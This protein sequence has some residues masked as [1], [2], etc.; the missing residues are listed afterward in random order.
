[1]GGIQLTYDRELRSPINVKLP[2]SKSM[3]ARALIMAAFAKV[4]PQAFS[5]LPDCNDTRELSAAIDWFFAGS[6][7]KYD[8]GTGGTSLR[9][10]TGFIA[11]IPDITAV[12]TCSEALGKRPLAPL[13]HALTDAG[14]DI[15]FIDREGY[16]PLL[17]S[18]KKIQGG[19]LEMSGNISSQFASSVMLAAP[20][21]TKGLHLK[22][23]GDSP[24]SMPYIHLTA[25]M[26]LNAGA[27][28]TVE[29][30][31]IT[32]A[33]GPYN[34]E[35]CVS[36]I[37]PDWSAASYFY[38]LALLCPEREIHFYR[39]TPP[40]TSLQGD[41]RC[42]DLFNLLGVENRYTEDGG[43]IVRC[44]T[45]KRDAI[46][47]MDIPLELD[48]SDTPDLVPALAVG[49]CLA[50]IKFSLSGVSHLRHKESDRLTALEIELSKI[51]YAVNIGEN[52]LSWTGSRTPI[53]ENESIETYGDH[54]IAMAFAIAAVRFP[55]LSI[56]NP[57]VSDKSFPNFFPT[58][59]SSGFHLRSFHA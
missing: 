24:V 47:N 55:Y 36:E 34:P 9:F 18:G 38:E 3:A 45:E 39:L 32:V 44:N 2:L 52:S 22:L 41:S 33:P 19:S 11:S 20:Y 49:L 23:I 28:V 42:A 59:E 57:E 7:K 58:L 6:G 25:S 53:G 14:A 40:S 1:M 10:F 16:A 12:L 50:G 4:R 8:L 29:G 35:K 37:E 54:R 30:K 17:V 31:E 51:G 21:W 26:M 48:M 46:K 15:D 56:L 5:E 27:K 13:C 43:A